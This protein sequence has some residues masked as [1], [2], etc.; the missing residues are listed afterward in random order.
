MAMMRRPSVLSG[1]ASEV[2]FVLRGF[3]RTPGYVA[4]AVLSLAIGIGANVATLSV[5]RAIVLQELPVSRPGELQWVNWTHPDG[6]RLVDYNSSNDS[7]YSYPAYETLRKAAGPGIRLLGFNFARRLALIAPGRPPMDATGM[8][9][10]GDFFT[11]LGLPVILGRQLGDGDNLAGAPPAAVISYDVWQRLYDGSPEV[12]GQTIRVNDVDFDVVGVTPRHYVGLSIG[13]FFRPTDVTLPLSAQPIAD[14]N[15]VGDRPLLGDPT[16]LW[17]HVIA[18]LPD[19]ADAERFRQAAVAALTPMDATLPTSGPLRGS[20][21]VTLAPANRGVDQVAKKAGEPLEILTGASFLVLFIACANLAALMLARGAARSRDTA[22]RRA[23]G[24][25]RATLIRQWLVESVMLACAG[26]LS[27]VLVAIWSGPAIVRLLTTGLGPVAIEL[28]TDWRLI[29]LALG[30]TLLT[31]VLSAAI[32]A[33]RLTGGRAT[34]DLRTQVIGASSPRLTIG[35]LLIA[36]QI[37]VSVPLLVGALLFLQTLRNLSAVDLGFDPSGVVEFQLNLPPVATAATG[38]QPLS[39]DTARLMTNLLAAFEAIPGVSSATIVENPLVNGISSN[40]RVLV[41]GQN[42]SMSMEAVGPR[43]FETMRMSLLSGR[44]IIDQDTASAPLVA[45]VNRAAVDQVFHGQSPIGQILRVGARNLAVVGVVDNAVYQ[46]LRRKPRPTFYDSY[47]QRPAM[48]IS[49]YVNLRTV[50]SPAS[51]IGPVTAIVAQ[52]A[53]T[54]PVSNFKTEND[55]IAETTGQERVFSRLLTLFAAFAIVLAGIGLYG[56]TSYAV[57]RRTNEIGIRLSL[58]APR[59]QV[60]ALML[61]QVVVLALVGLVA[62]V[63]LALLLARFV[64]TFVFGI[65]PRDPE[66]FVI[67]A[68]TMLAAAIAAGWVPARRAARLEPLSA[69]RTE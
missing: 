57:A 55:Q 68:M 13:G 38:S 18:R 29:A 47:L 22:V 65:A 5:M 20:T 67:V 30:L 4:V 32:P 52:M 48:T 24:A 9:V 25:S 33:W 7:N 17:I 39:P 59:G 43:F 16:R 61:R 35:R 60:Q 11:T 53:P 56:L 6:L 63:P 62:G 2:R 45:V 40:T 44:A 69:L 46:S 31:A 21:A 58:G 15:F 14:P 27:G 64:G 42:A 26:G 1:F 34:S 36:G 8:I 28:S 23:L 51:V 49:P 37:A 54:A 41:D 19:A 10:S 3:A 50:V 66:T 12:V